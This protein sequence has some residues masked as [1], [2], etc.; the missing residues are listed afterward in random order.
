MTGLRR[1]RR[2]VDGALEALDEAIGGGRWLH[3]VRDELSAL[4]RQFMGAM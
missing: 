1:V 4:E 2:H 3:E